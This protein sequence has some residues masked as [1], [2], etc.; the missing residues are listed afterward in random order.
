MEMRRRSL[1]AFV[2]AALLVACSRGQ[3][4]TP[5]TLEAVAIA[6]S[7]FPGARSYDQEPYRGLADLVAPF[8][9][10]H[11][12][13]TVRLRLPETSSR[14]TVKSVAEDADCFA[15]GSDAVSAENQEVI[16][17]VGPFLSAGISVDAG[18][19]YPALLE[20]FTWQ[21]WLWGL[22]GE[23]MP[24]V[25]K[26]NRDLF[27]AAGVPYPAADWTTDEFL[28]TA[29]AL[30]RGAGDEKQ[31]GFVSAPFEF[32]E[33]WEMLERR[34]ASLVD[35]SVDPPT[36][37]FDDP[38]TVEALRWY[39]GLTTEYGVK[40]VFVTVEE[41]LSATSP[42]EMEALEAAFAERDALIRD[43]RAAI[44][45]ISEGWELNSGQ[46]VLNVGVAPLP[47]GVD[48]SS[49]AYLSVTGYYISARASV[50]QAQAC[51]EWIVYLTGQPA[52]MWGAPAR[53][54]VMES[55]AYRQQVG[56][57]R[58][59]AYAASLT[60][61]E[62]LSGLRRF[63][64]QFWLMPPIVWLNRAYAQ[65]VEGEASPE[66]ALDAAQQVFD[67]YRACVVA[68]D[69]VFDQEGVM[70]CLQEADPALFALMTS[71]ED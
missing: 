1:L 69:A 40:P 71:T 16:R 42:E 26:Y 44:W 15:W 19:F 9:E 41:L 58:A 60:G 3:T 55:A 27:D 23:A 39:T 54:S 13:I 32:Y 38:A 33:L 43:G 29:I 57:E 51:W 70:A 64:N 18:D 12:H 5:P 17:D 47:A 21:G 11:P 68:R 10:T 20:E 14:L 2:L 56:E 45:A 30:T 36:L 59:A 48:G 7:P 4:A 66:D 34:G 49:G 46:G 52:V 6:F 37:A 53:R 61:A 50:P 67:E 8:Q 22:P 35:E 24:Y 63:T 28:Q 65:V 31:Y 62:R 25:L